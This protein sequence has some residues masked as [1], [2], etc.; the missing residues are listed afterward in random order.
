MKVRFTPSAQSQFLAKLEFVKADNPLA[1]AALLAR[2]KK[3]LR[4][5]SAHPQSG[6]RIPEFPELK[7]REVIV[8][9]YRFFYRWRKRPSGSSP[10][11][12]G[13]NERPPNS[14]PGAGDRIK[15]VPSCA[16]SC[17]PASSCPVHPGL[18]LEMLWTR[19][20]TLVFGSTTLAVSTVLTAFMGGL[21]LGSYLAGRFADRLEIPVRAYALA[22][23]AIGVYALLVPWCARLLPGAQP[24]A[25]DRAFGD[26][27][28]LLSMLRFVGVGR[29]PAAPDH[30]DGRRRCR[31]WP[32]TSS[33][34][35][36]SCGARA[37]HRD[38]L[39]GQPVRRGRRRVPRRVRV[40]A[41]CSASPGPTSPRPSS[42]SRWRRPSSLARRRVAR[43]RRRRR[44][45]R[46]APGRGAPREAKLEPRR[47]RRRWSTP[48]AR[49]AALA[50]F[51]V[52][53]ATAMTLQV[54]W[55]RALAV[56]LG[57]SVFSF[58]LILLAF[59]IGLGVGRRGVRRA[60]ASGRRTRCAGWRR[61]TWAIAAAVGL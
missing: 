37:A 43:R 1:A 40:P 4:R 16:R 49:R 22:E 14:R 17:S 35:P 18:I 15:S 27:Y 29:A 39:R 23:A 8:P 45:L 46:R 34:G 32:A 38:A 20:L 36:G 50:A 13:P 12:T 25:C 58:T 21:G 9:P 24:L 7:H 26:R 52:S 30:A 28:V 56:L 51:A 59:L 54:L 41:R 10:S 6:R 33:R 31:C 47:C 11:G 53:G 55:T 5:L 60:G 42:T 19:M 44:Q 61:C 57:S 48:R 2:A 3:S